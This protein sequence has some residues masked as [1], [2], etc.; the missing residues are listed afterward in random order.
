MIQVLPPSY[1][2]TSQLMERHISA[3]PAEE[4]PLKNTSGSIYGKSVSPSPDIS[5]FVP[6]GHI[7]LDAWAA[8]PL[9]H[10]SAERGIYSLTSFYVSKALQ[11]LGLGGTALRMCEE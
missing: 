9:L 5:A 2:R 11:S 10:T 4:T 1:E 3:F 7:S 8:D 6:V